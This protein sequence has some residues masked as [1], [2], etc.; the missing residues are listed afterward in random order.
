MIF[1][2][3]RT[4]AA[5]ASYTLTIDDEDGVNYYTE[6]FAPDNG[7]KTNGIFNVQVNNNYSP[8]VHNYADDQKIS[9]DPLPAGN[10]TWTVKSSVT[11]TPTMA[12][13]TFTID[14][15]NEVTENPSD[16]VEVSFTNEDDATKISKVSEAIRA[17]D[18][19][20]YAI[21]EAMK[22]VKTPD[23]YSWIGGKGSDNRAFVFTHSYTKEDATLSV[24]NDEGTLLYEETAQ[25]EDAT[26][27]SKG[28]FFIQVTQSE[29]GAGCYNNV[30]NDKTTDKV[31]SGGSK[32]LETGTYRYT[33][34]SEDTGAVLVQGEMAITNEYNA[35]A[36]AA[37]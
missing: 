17:K 13:G 16:K 4:G 26:V 33:V 9:A 15:L 32:G 3:P 35:N 30:N 8:D 23:G 20:V 19:G 21:P 27:G 18:P 28:F 36:G 37:E 14:K 10:Y 24:Y 22:G 34:R 2:Y 1:I 29:P 6:S 5:N 25:F 12:T 31:L 11:G 7:T